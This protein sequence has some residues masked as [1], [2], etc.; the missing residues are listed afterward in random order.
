MN[1]W[2]T[3][4][5]KLF[6]AA[7]DC[8]CSLCGRTSPASRHPSADMQNPPGGFCPECLK[9]LDREAAVPCRE[10][11]KPAAQC[12][13]PDTTLSPLPGF[14]QGHT[15]LFH[16]W[17]MGGSGAEPGVEGTLT[18]KM[19]LQCK[20]RYSRNIIRYIART[21]AADL[22][23]L[24]PP[25]KR[26]DWVLTYAPR[27]RNSYLQYGFDQCEEIVQIMGRE[28]GIPVKKLLVR[29]GGDE[30][31]AMTN[32][33]KRRIN[34]E[35]AFVLT[36]TLGKPRNLQ[37]CRIL[38]FDDIIT[39]G[40]TMRSAGRVLAEAGAAAVFPIAFAKSIFRSRV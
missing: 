33:E 27:S 28:L 4:L 2:H 24:I 3:L 26:K 29:S 21:T 22:A 14:L 37:G 19:L 38:L 18:A 17:Y 11:G 9:A 8:T 16:S 23:P 13:C 34:T 36:K 30:Q 31:K 12:E 35:N 15:R 39:T 20:K 25:A 32:A 10:C 6:S 5:E 40:A 7:G 1:N